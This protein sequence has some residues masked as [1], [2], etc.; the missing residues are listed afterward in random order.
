ILISIMIMGVGLIS[1]ATLFPLGLLRIRSANRDSRSTLLARSAI[2]EVDTRN[3]FDKSTF[4]FGWYQSPI[5]ATGFDP[6]IVD[7]PPAASPTPVSR[8]F[9][10]G[11]PVAYDPLFWSVVHQASGA[12]A[13][14]PLAGYHPGTVEA[15]FGSG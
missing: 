9:G 2:G 1:L 15:R 10:P 13:A 4:L 6:W 5:F 7:G 3:L 14:N 12:T 8:A 11:L